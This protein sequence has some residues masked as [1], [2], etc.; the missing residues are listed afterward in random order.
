MENFT[1]IANI[2]LLILLLYLGF[3][4]LK[5]FFFISPAKPFKWEDGIEKN[6]ISK[7]LQKL[8]KKYSDKTRFYNFW[9]QI[10]R[11]R[12]NNIIGAFAE[13]GVYKGETAMLI[14][15]MAPNKKL[16]LFDT[17]EGFENADLKLENSNDKKYSKKEFAD[18]SA[19]SVSKY[20][21]TDEHIHIIQGY[22]PESTVNLKEEKYAFVH[23]DADLYKP[24]IEALSYFYS[25]LSSGGVIIIHDYNH[26]WAGVRKAVDEFKAKI[27]E[28]IIELTDWQGSVMIIKS[29]KKLQQ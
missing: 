14:H 13:L 25:R 7:E 4:I 21:G 1:L 27:S 6:T 12:E 10:E 20:L 17:F 29:E 9:F 15:K 11:I 2:I 24:T 22:F 28:P 19:E 3:R 18:T 8:E 16:Y 23:I 26:N 5:A